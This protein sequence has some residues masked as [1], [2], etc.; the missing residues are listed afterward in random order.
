[1]STIRKTTTYT[2]VMYKR[3]KKKADRLGL[4]FHEYLKHLIAS[5]ISG[6]YIEQ[7]SPGLEKEIGKALED[8]K[9]GRVYPLDP[10]DKNSMD[11]LKSGDF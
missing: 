6:E 11:K 3:A 1:M 2:S 8:V 4:T 5:D 7:A 9:A 10:F